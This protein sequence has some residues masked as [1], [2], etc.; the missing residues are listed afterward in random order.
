VLSLPTKGGHSNGCGTLDFRPIDGAMQQLNA[1]RV[2]QVCS[3]AAVWFARVCTTSGGAG[4]D[5]GIS[6]TRL[7]RHWYNS[8]SLPAVKRKR[9]FR[10]SYSRSI[11]PMTPVSVCRQHYVLEIQI[12]F[13]G[14]D[15]IQLITCT[16]LLL[17]FIICYHLQYEVSTPVL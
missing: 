1:R 11:A 10:Q 5:A 4:V 8:Q 9:Q 2:G 3:R 13:F 7:T 15:T 17:Q 12:E 6:A 14:V 16:S